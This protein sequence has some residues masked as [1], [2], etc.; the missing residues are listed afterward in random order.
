M[1]AL[2]TIFGS[3][4]QF[5]SLSNEGAQAVHGSPKALHAMLHECGRQPALDVFE[6]ARLDTRGGVSDLD[7][8][9]AVRVDL[10]LYR[11]AVMQRGHAAV[12]CGRTSGGFARTL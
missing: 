9:R 7:S 11:V 10:A 8:I 6:L 5:Y 12:P 2:Q 4:K 3:G 1:F